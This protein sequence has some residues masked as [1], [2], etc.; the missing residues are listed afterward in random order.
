MDLKVEAEQGQRADFP[1]LGT[2][3]VVRGERTGGRFAL[4]E[5]TMAPRTLAAP[6]HVHENED[7][8]SFVLRGRMGAHVGDDEVE[9][10]PGE[11][12]FKPRKIP[13][14][15]WNPGDEETRLLELISPAGFE[16]YFEE[17]APLLSVEGERDLAALGE[18]RARY[19]LAMDPA[20]IGPL[21]E[22]HGLRA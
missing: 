14:A 10:G 12:V 19:S 16:D 18:I 11:F 9:A 21:M 17:V 13:H 2:R 5:H 15:F 6:T 22:R 4:V 3:Y 1:G 20:T 8:Y 7:E